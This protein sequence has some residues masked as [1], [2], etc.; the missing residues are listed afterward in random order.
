MLVALFFLLYLF[1]LLNLLFC[2]VLAVRFLCQL[3]IFS[4]LSL[5]PSLFCFVLPSV[6]PLSLHILFF[7]P[8]LVSFWFFSPLP[9]LSFL[10]LLTFFLFT[11]LSLCLYSYFITIP[12]YLF[13]SIIRTY[14]LTPSALHSFY[15]I[16]QTRLTL[17]MNWFM[18]A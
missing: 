8:G 7:R 5:H 12:E 9:S 16:K 17:K 6:P 11:S 15:I 14:Y 18:S 2:P 13:Y 1:S 10:F 4:L 3:S